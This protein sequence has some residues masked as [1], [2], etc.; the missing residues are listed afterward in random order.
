MRLGCSESERQV[1]NSSEIFSSMLVGRGAVNSRVRKSECHQYLTS[2][3]ANLGSYF[4][5]CFLIY[6]FVLILKKVNCK[7][8]RRSLGVPKRNRALPR[9]RSSVSPQQ[10]P[11]A[12]FS[13]TR[14]FFV[15]FPLGVAS[16]VA[17]SKLVPAL[18]NSSDIPLDPARVCL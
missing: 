6:L 4:V 18:L 5:I 14:C 2:T 10:P 16:Q 12:S 9:H 7:V 1:R 17:H 8:G 13:Q 11:R 15:F 3:S